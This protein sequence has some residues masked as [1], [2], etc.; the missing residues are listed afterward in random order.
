MVSR[1]TISTIGSFSSQ[2]VM[3]I[4]ERRLWSRS[5]ELVC[6]ARRAKTS[7]RMADF[8]REWNEMYRR[9]QQAEIVVR[10]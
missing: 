1:R 7:A 5:E 8:Q 3:G 2:A 9:T 6:W 4:A 10:T